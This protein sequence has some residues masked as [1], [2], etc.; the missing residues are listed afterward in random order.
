MPKSRRKGK[1]TGAKWA[2]ARHRTMSA[3]EADR[4]ERA[5]ETRERRDGQREIEEQLRDMEDRS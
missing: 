3:A 4:C 5:I 2:V 1:H